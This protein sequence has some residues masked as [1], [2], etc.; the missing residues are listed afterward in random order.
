MYAPSL[1]RFLQADPI[2]YGNGM[3]RYVYVGN[4]PVNRGDPTGTIWAVSGHYCTSTSTGNPV[5]SGLVT[6]AITCYPQWTWIDDN[7]RGPAGGGH[8]NDGDPVEVTVV[9]K[10]RPIAPKS[11]VVLIATRAP[12][13]A[14]EDDIDACKRAF[15]YG[16][17]KITRQNYLACARS[18]GDRLAERSR[19]RTPGPLVGVDTPPPYRRDDDDCIKCRVEERRAN[20]GIS[21][22]GSPLGQILEGILGGE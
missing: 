11:A 15:P 8:A 21:P 19:G 16:Q 10:R 6:V 13:D 7:P 3:N 12:E 18:A 9:G 17:S 20:N 14:Y 2:G 5:G 1:G 22:G 4:D